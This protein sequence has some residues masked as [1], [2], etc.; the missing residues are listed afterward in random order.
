MLFYNEIGWMSIGA[1]KYLKI[2]LHSEGMR[3]GTVSK[4]LNFSTVSAVTTGLVCVARSTV[5]S[6]IFMTLYNDND[7]I[8]LTHPQ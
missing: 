8:A 4:P 1:K 5:L 2:I 6:T 3:N 7:F